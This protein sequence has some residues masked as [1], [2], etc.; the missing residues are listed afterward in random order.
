[1]NILYVYFNHIEHFTG[2]DQTDLLLLK[3]SVGN[4]YC[5]VA[6]NSPQANH[7][8]G[9]FPNREVTTGDSSHE[10][11][12]LGSGALLLHEGLLYFK[13]LTLNILACLLV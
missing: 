12:G 3:P 11:V 13:Y 7:T 2:E 9:S 4:S 5:S 8:Y 10:E 1:M 6:N